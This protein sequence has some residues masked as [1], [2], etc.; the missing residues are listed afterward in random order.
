MRGWSAAEK[1]SIVEKYVTV[2]YG[3]KLKWLKDQGV[4]YDQLKSWRR[5]F[6]FGDLERDLVPRDTAH[7]TVADGARLARL[8]RELV[9]ER[10]ARARE[11]A[12]HEG[13]L[14]RLQATNEALG[15]A[16]GLLHEWN[17]PQEPTDES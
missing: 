10:A 8:E 2:A 3:S 4:S 17:A 1:A 15:K 7:M 12:Q 16:I 14:A 9:A 13:H 6:Y 5:A 11:R